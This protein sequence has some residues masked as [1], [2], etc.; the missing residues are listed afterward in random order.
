MDLT[1][2]RL[3]TITG[4]NRLEEVPSPSWPL[5]LSPQ[6]IAE[7]LSKAAHVCF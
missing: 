2:L 5:A 6:H 3:A 4:V 7:P 1:L